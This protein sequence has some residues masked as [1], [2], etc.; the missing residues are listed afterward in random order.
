MVFAGLKFSQGDVNS[1]TTLTLSFLFVQ[2]SGV[3]EESFPIFGSL[4]FKL[5]D[6]SFVD[7]TTFVD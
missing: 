4:L 2:D 5:F 7:S 1:D 6:G 3:L